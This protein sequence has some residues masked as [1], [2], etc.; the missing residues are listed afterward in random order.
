MNVAPYIR[1]CHIT[2]E[3]ILNSSVPTNKLGY[4][5][6]RIRWLTDK[7]MLYLSVYILYSSI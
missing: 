3:Y 7:F 4:V 2:N 1:W 6:R 5:R